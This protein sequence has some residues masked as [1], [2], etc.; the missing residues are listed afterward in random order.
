MTRT[1]RRPLRGLASLLAAAVVLAACDGGNGFK[2]PVGSGNGNGSGGGGAAAADT[3]KP[4]L[5]IEFP[6]D[7][8]VVAIADSVFVQV[9]V[10]DNQRLGSL[11]LAGFSV[12]GDRSLGTDSVYPRFGAK[13]VNLSQTTRRDTT[14]TR[15][16]IATADSTS[17]RRVMVVATAKDS[18]GNS[19]ADT[20]Y[21]NIGGP[22][23]QIVAPV[24]NDSFP[25]GGQLPVRVSAEDVN[26]L[27]RSVVVRMT[28]AFAREIVIPIATPR[29]KVDTTVSV[30][31]PAV[32]GPLT[33]EAVA[34]SG[35]N[36]QA[37]SRPVAVRITAPVADRTAPQVTFSADSVSRRQGGDTVKV[38]VL[39]TDETAVDSVGATL[40]VRYRDPSTGA[41]VDRYLTDRRRGAQDTARIPL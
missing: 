3:T 36:I 4:T 15:Y 17:E 28:G 26:D 11:S 41:A 21:I 39:A 20:A 16:L 18:A 7:S 1:T 25:A 9:K 2:D 19:R 27:I 22:R 32:T 35:S 13:S 37:T 40:R 31:V 14:I 12:R 23:V 5:T 38:W 10:A 34:T 30:A 24:Q 33:I 6:R 29:A 8:A